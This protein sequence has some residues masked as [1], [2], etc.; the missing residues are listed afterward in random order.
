MDKQ[1]YDRLVLEARRWFMADDN[2]TLSHK[3]TMV[4]Q[5]KP[6]SMPKH[7]YEALLVVVAAR[8]WKA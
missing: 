8:L 6:R 7:E 3:L 4:S 1:T 2:K 5:G